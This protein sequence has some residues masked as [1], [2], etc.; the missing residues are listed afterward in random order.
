M[1]LSKK[2]KGASQ[3]QYLRVTQMIPNLEYSI[4]RA[5]KPTSRYGGSV[6]FFIRDI[7]NCNDQLYKVLLPL[8]YAEAVTDFDIYQINDKVWV[9]L[10]FR[11]LNKHGSA[12]RM[13]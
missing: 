12:V 8:Q 3:C 4:Q 5:V 1:E 2:L 13:Y 7:R 10:V 11:V 9:T 6:Y